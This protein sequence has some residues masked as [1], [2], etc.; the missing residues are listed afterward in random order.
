MSLTSPQYAL[1]RLFRL[2]DDQLIAFGHSH[3]EQEIVE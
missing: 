3:V 2:I 1:V